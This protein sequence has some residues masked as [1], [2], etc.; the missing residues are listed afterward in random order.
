MVVR[1]FGIVF[2]S[3]F[4]NTEITLKQLALRSIASFC[5]SGLFLSKVDRVWQYYLQ[6]VQ[7][8]ELV[9]HPE[10]RPRVF[11]RI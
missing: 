8:S 5:V 3:S 10:S 9:K 2:S 11:L 7:D 6:P 4:E 1:S